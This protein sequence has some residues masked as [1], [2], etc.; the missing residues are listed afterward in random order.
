MNRIAN[1]LVP[2]KQSCNGTRLYPTF[3]YNDTACMHSVLQMYNSVPPKARSAAATFAFMPSHVRS[4]R[5]PMTPRH[6]QNAGPAKIIA[7]ERTHRK[8]YCRNTLNLYCLNEQAYLPIIKAG[9][10]Q[11]LLSDNTRP[12]CSLC[13]SC[14]TA[15]V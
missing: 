12:F 13:V 1:L 6:R 2:L 7:T 11:L 9:R 14:Q 15:S 8:S 10:K 5:D 3:S 4:K